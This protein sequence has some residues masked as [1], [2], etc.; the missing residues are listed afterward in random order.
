MSHKKILWGRVFLFLVLP[1]ILIVAV[2]IL[3]CRACEHRGEEVYV[4]PE[5]E[6]VAEPQYLY[7]I[8]IDSMY[9]EEGKVESGQFLSTLLCSKGVDSQVVEHIAREERDVFD[10]S[11]MRAGNKYTF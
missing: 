3:C 10:V 1:I 2:I 6:V 5:E 9:V 4:E 7:G 8:C 11:K